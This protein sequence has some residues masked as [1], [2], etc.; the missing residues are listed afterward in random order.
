MRITALIAA[1]VAALAL[2]AVTSPASA[3]TALQEP[4][5]NADSYAIDLRQRLDTERRG[6][7][8]LHDAGAASVSE[9][10]SN[11]TVALGAAGHRGHVLLN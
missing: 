10:M 9:Q 7:A 4:V 6:H 3:T 8:N 11:S 5:V 2:A 1:S